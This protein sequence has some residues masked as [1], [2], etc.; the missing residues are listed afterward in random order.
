MKL[1]AGGGNNH[2]KYLL[3]QVC[4]VRR[5]AM[6]GVMFVCPRVL[7]PL[8]MNTRWSGHTMLHGHHHGCAPRG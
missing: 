5:R 6:W 3:L 1:E 2:Y 7:L 4:G 8:F